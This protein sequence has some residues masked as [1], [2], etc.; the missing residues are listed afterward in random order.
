MTPK[1]LILFKYKGQTLTLLDY[2]EDDEYDMDRFRVSLVDSVAVHYGVARDEEVEVIRPNKIE[3]RA[4]DQGVLRQADA[5][6]VE[7][8]KR[9]KSQATA[10]DYDEEAIRDSLWALVNAVYDRTFTQ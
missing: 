6:L 3:R 1:V 2:G 9:A 10:P 8:A 4:L 7:L 5:D